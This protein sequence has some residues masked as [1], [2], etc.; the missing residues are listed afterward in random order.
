EG[1]HYEQIGSNDV[2]QLRTRQTAGIKE[3]T[4]VAYVRTQAIPRFCTGKTPGG[5]VNDF[6][7]RCRRGIYHCLRMSR[8]QSGKNI[9]RYA[10]DSV[11]TQQQARTGS[12]NSG[13]ENLFGL[14]S[15]LKMAR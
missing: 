14:G 4:V 11:T 10:D 13:G 12:G 2:S 15:F 3:L 5:I 1:T 8:I 6:G 7:C 9:R